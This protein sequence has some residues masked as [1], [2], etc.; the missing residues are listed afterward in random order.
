MGDWDDSDVGASCYPSSKPEPSDFC[1]DKSACIG[2]CNGTWIIGFCAYSATGGSDDPCAIEMN[3]QGTG[4][5]Y[6]GSPSRDVMHASCA[7]SESACGGCNGT[8]C[9]YF[10]SPIY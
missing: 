1:D 2:E 10:K 5:I 9:H 6:T 8:F 7:A 3:V 4:Y